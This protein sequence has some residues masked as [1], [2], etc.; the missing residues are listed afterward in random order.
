MSDDPVTRHEFNAFAKLMDE[1]HG[2]G[3][4]ALTLA[5]RVQE[6]RFEQVNNLR[7]QVNGERGLYVTQER[8]DVVTVNIERRV[9]ELERGRANQSGNTSATYIIF[10]VVVAILTMAIGAAGVYFGVHR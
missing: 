10:T 4:E 2:S 1:R 3:K 6:A 9:S 8:Y 7:E 5:Q